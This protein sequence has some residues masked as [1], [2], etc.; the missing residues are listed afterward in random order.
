[1]ESMLK[2]VPLI[3]FMTMLKFV[4]GNAA[5]H[6]EGAG[7]MNFKGIIGAIADQNSRNGKEEIV[8]IEMALEDFYHYSNQRF[9]L[10]IRNS[11]GD[12][13]KAALAA[14]DLINEMH[15]QAIIGPQTWEETSLV[16]EVCNQSMTPVLSLADATPK[17]STLK[18]PFLLQASPS[19][20][21]QMKVV[22]AIVQ[23]WEWYSVNII[24]EG[25]DASSS[26]VISHLYRALSEAGVSIS[27]LLAIPHFVSLSLSQELE[28]L[29]EG[30]CRVFV[31]ISSLPLAINLFETANKMNMIEKDS[32]WIITDPFTS[33]VH[34][35]NAST[36]SSM[37]GIL[38]IKS[39]IPETGHQ[40]KDF[41]H[42]FGQKFSSEN[43][44]EFN[45]EP[46]VFAAHAYDAA[47][48]V[49]LA[50]S[51]IN[52][53][54]GQV[55]LDKI[56]LNSFIGLSGKIQFTDQKL[57]PSH[58][59]QI[60][61]VIGNGYKEIGFWSDGLGFSNSI[62]QNATYSFSMKE[63]G[64]LLWPG[65]PW[66]T[67]R[68][69]ALPT[70]DKPLRVGVPAL[71]T[72][73]QFINI[74]QDHSTNTTS[75]DGF[76][77]DL[78]RE[79]VE[80]LPYHLPYKLYAFNDTYDN[81]VKQV[82]LKN[83]DAAIDV[84]IISYRYQYAE[85]TQPYTDPGVVMV[86]PIKS[87]AGH[88]AWLFVK[89]FTKTMWILI[90]AMIIYNGFV[91]WML[92]RHHWPELKGSMLNQTG[93]M[94]WLALTPLISFNGG[95]L[96]HSLSRM[97]MVVWLF[98]ALIITQSYTANLTSMLTVER[99]EPL[100]D[101]VD[102]LRNGNAVVGYTTG[103]FL[104]KYLQ[105][106]LHFQP[107]K[108]KQFSSLE[109][110]AEALRKKEIA[111]AF[112]EVPWAKIFLSKY[113]KEFIQA[114]PMYKFGGFGFAFPRGSP[115][116]PSVNKALLSL[117]ETGKLLELENQML[118]SEKCEDT[119]PDAD[120]A[121]LSPNSFWALF[122]LTAGTST[123][124]LLVY[125]VGMYYS[126]REEKTSWRLIMVMIQQYEYAK[127]RFSR[128]ESDVTESSMYSPNAH[129]TPTQV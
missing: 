13:L 101:N 62:G 39:Y 5:A 123:I 7:G 64:Q 36:I 92:E 104:Q 25:R 16:A 93:T 47:W 17:W 31:V 105:E 72:L 11:Q 53:K 115:Y 75:F 103:S 94:A 45:N 86:V 78:L 68:G 58:T 61:N 18:L 127:R 43:P 120:S 116:L 9:V 4:L 33:L 37:Q 87:K 49:A 22:A 14:R 88:R 124:S 118:A 52:S 80:L 102:Q 38:G 91:L 2:F 110:F 50:M 96:H 51:Q 40:F 74:N 23:S 69:W 129:A 121:S 109:E 83:F 108:M 98:V 46:G 111:A 26:Q 113:C 84:T 32:V 21:K 107:A 63:L 60:I 24:Y 29:R 95:K 112:L 70:S 106:V 82:Y 89:P 56:L 6:P 128:R 54:G 65:R 77:I 3:C 28:K 1:M 71:A 34:S 73:K 35:L 97:A 67:P 42:K 81:L 19:Q 57:A 44:W 119:E 27:N 85:F 20:F 117:F 10:H 114:G 55:L 76:T 41:Y 99:L 122:T 126:N 30:P 66:D 90:A 125:I 79:T 100:V 48:T 12:P 15:V 59:F 8:A